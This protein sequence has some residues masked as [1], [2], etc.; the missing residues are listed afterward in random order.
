MG[1]FK[2]LDVRMQERAARQSV[3]SGKACQW[4]YA[5]TNSARGTIE[6]PELGVISICLKCRKTVEALERLTR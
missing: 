2:D 1:Y 5:C 6:H 3:V 4:Y